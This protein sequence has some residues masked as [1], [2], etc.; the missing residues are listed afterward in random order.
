MIP[1]VIVP[2]SALVMAT[3]RCQDFPFF[4]N[5]S[6]CVSRKLVGMNVIAQS[7]ISST[8]D[9]FR[10]SI[11][12][13]LAVSWWTERSKCDFHSSMLDAAQLKSCCNSS[14]LSGLKMERVALVNIMMPLHQKFLLG[15]FLPKNK[16]SSLGFY[17][18]TALHFKQIFSL[19]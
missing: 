15:S 3:V 10:L 18:Q 14:R 11:I 6:R 19:S 4:P 16:N 13:L 9:G 12:S 17:S 1:T 5:Q 7:I 2:S 8:C